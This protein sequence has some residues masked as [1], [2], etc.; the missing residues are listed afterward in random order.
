MN[1]QLGD[2]RPVLDSSTPF[3]F[4]KFLT[5]NATKLFNLFKNTTKF[6]LYLCVPPMFLN[7][8]Y[9]KLSNKL[10]KKKEKTEKNKRNK[11]VKKK[12]KK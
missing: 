3:S 9:C 4:L 8:C 10:K 7:V 12:K 6:F 11:L 5:K 1:Q 2:R